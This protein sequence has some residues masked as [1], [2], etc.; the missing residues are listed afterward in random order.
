MDAEFDF[1]L[2][3]DQWEM[4][5]ALRLPPHQRRRANM[6]PGLERLMTL[7]LAAWMAESPV[8]TATGRK[9]LIRGSA[10]LMDLRA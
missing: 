5:R 6:Q 10:K 3:L 9:V 2:S 4:L 8:I 7:G 1:D